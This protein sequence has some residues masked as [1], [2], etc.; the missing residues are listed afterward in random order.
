MAARKAIAVTDE[1]VTAAIR[2]FRPFVDEDGH[3]T[4]LN[5]RAAVE[6]G[7]HAALQVQSV[8]DQLISKARG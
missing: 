3:L 5:V 2:A 1:M 6:A 8:A 7:L 4:A